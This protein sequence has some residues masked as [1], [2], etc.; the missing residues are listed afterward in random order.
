MADGQNRDDETARGL[1]RLQKASIRL[2]AQITDVTARSSRRAMLTQG[3]LAGEIVLSMMLANQVC[4][5]MALVDLFDTLEPDLP[6]PTPI[7]ENKV[8]PVQH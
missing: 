2:K 5:M 1:S 8:G 7:E 4:I 6:P 3:P